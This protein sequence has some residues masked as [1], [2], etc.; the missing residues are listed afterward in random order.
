MK[1]IRL[2]RTT[3]SRRGKKKKAGVMILQK[4]FVRR[5][6]VETFVFAAAIVVLNACST[7]NAGEE[8]AQF[9]PKSG[10][11]QEIPGWK[12]GSYV[13]VNG[14]RLYYETYGSG[15]PVLLLHGGSAAIESYF[16]QIPELAKRF[17]VIAPDSRG[18]G[19]TQDSDKPLSYDLMAADCLALLGHLKLT[20]VA[21]IG[22]SDGG[23]IGLH[24]AM[25]HPGLVRKL[26]TIG[27]NF[28]PDGMTEEFQEGLKS[29][30]PGD[31]PEFL[32]DLYKQL[33]PDG[34]DHFP[35]IYGKL[36]T[37]W[38][39][40]PNFTTNQLQTIKCPAL[41]MVGDHDFVKLE[42]TTELFRNLPNGQLCVIPGATHFSPVENPSLVNKVL[43]E[44]LEAKSAPGQ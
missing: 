44:F 20:N 28:R 2:P 8:L 15:D 13:V 10:P 17:T 1:F 4:R 30:G 40:S 36:K 18:Q 3:S 38:T 23:V 41:I 11:I 9:R 31:H 35:T 12:P 21:V 19:R 27:G 32:V 7:I 22:W 24:L 39:T 43:M 34:P 42:H 37:L 26:V 29:S 33:T 6:I 5:R 16:N 25:N 14:I